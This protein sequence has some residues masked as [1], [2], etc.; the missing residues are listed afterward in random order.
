[1]TFL[2]HKLEALKQKDVFSIYEASILA[3][4]SVQTLRKRIAEGQLNATQYAPKGK[5]YIKASDLSKFLGVH[6]E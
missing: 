3:S 2:N 4:Q 5:W 1:M 6:Y